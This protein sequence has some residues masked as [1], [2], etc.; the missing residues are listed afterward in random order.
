MTRKINDN[1]YI[2]ELPNDML[3]SNTFNV[4]DLFEYHLDDPLDGY[5]NSIYDEFF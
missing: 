2:V 1:A 5:N 3:I 4:V